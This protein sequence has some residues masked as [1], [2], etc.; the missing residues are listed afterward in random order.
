MGFV[1]AACGGGLGG[2]FCGSILML[3]PH[4]SKLAHLPYTNR[5]RST[6]KTNIKWKL[7]YIYIYIYIYISHTPLE[8]LSSQSSH[9][10]LQACLLVL[11][12][13]RLVDT[14]CIQSRRVLLYPGSMLPNLHNSPDSSIGVKA[15]YRNSNRNRYDTFPKPHVVQMYCKRN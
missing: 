9:T 1:F 2:C 3:A 10:Q 14:C 5:A 12:I 4:E 6:R 15:W 11:D 8:S 13:S 7:V